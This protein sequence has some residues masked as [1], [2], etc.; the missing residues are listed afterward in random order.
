VGD[1]NPPSLS[2]PPLG[3]PVGQLTTLLSTE[4]AR[5][6]IFIQTTHRCSV[7]E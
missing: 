2:Q 3:T 7:K 4:V 1:L 6:Q 5:R